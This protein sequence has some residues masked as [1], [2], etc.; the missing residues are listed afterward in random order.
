[1][2]SKFIIFWYS[3]WYACMTVSMY[4][5]LGILFVWEVVF[6]SF[7]ELISEIFCDKVFF[8]L[9]LYNLVHVNEVSDRTASALLSPI[10]SLVAFVVF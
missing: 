2:S 8:I 9:S 3:I 6:S 1:M 10:K 4:P 5:S 7:I